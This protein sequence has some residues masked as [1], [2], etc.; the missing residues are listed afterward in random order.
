[1]NALDALFRDEVDRQ[2]FTLRESFERCAHFP[3]DGEMLFAAQALKGAARV[4][5]IREAERI[6]DAFE[7]MIST[8]E[9]AGTMLSPAQ[10][11]ACTDS[12]ELIEAVAQSGSATAS[13]VA[14]EAQIVELLGRLSVRAAATAPTRRNK[15]LTSVPAGT[16]ELFRQECELHAN[17]LNEGLLSL[18]KQPDQPELIDRLM[19]A[20]HSIKG[21]ARAVG[22]DAAVVLAHAA[23]D[24]LE[25]ARRGQVLISPD[26]VDA[27]LAA[28]DFFQRIGAAAAASTPPPNDEA[29]LDCAERINQAGLQAAVQSSGNLVVPVERKALPPQTSD[30]AAAVSTTAKTAAPTR[31]AGDDE[32]TVRIRAGQLSRLVAMSG[33]LV[34]ETSQHRYLAKEH[35][36]LRIKLLNIADSLDTLQQTIATAAVDGRIRT[37]VEDLKIQLNDVRVANS[38]WSEDHELYLRRKEDLVLRLYGEAI[39]SRMRPVADGLTAFPRLVRDVAKR[40]GKQVSLTISGENHRIDRDIL[41]RIEAPLNHLLRNA[42]DHGLEKPVVRRDSGKPEIGLIRIEI[43]VASGSMEIT[44]IDDGTGIDL[45]KVRKRVVAMGLAS[46]ESAQQLSTERLLD[47][48]F[49]SGFSTAEQVTELSGRGVGLAVVRSVMRDIGG[50][51]NVQTEAGRGARFQLKVPISRSV[52]RAVVV[53]IGGEAYAFALTRVDQVLRLASTEVLIAENRRYVVR[54]GRTITLIAASEV[55][56]FEPSTASPVALDIVVVSSFGHHIGFIVDAVRGEQDMVLQ[57]IDARLGRVPNLSA[58]AVLPDG[59]PVLIIDTDDMIRSALNRDVLQVREF[60]LA[61]RNAGKKAVHI[62]VVDDS[63]TV[64]AME[65]ELLEE[66]GFKVTLAADGMEAWGVMRDTDFDLVVTD[67]DMPRLDGIGLI[68][69]IRQDGRL[70]KV[71]IIVMSYRAS[72]E[73]RQRGL[74]AG[75]N[76]YLTKADYED[77]TLLDNVYRLLPTTDLQ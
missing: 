49:V 37:R 42:L 48:L 25:R 16:L 61:G 45:A 19:R 39:D 21:A 56:E 24:Q 35:Q 22:L 44:V 64:R 33:E 23:E 73:E 63:P 62:L 10:L 29:V 34:V 51:V 8:A 7:T 18:E 6:A 50:S 41:E 59:Q 69:S 71:P 3:P 15:P 55:L 17:T 36:R 2:A 9:S 43:R 54:E 14:P 5:G 40:L 4:V 46:V 75:A 77:Q 20:S 11:Q 66:A 72:A 28:G 60:G 13:E 12:L 70:R 58:A 74:D 57:A 26:L 76:I 67:V 65:R 68:R 1:M 38:M 27:L 47:Q 31:T 32:R 30:E 52:L 53:M